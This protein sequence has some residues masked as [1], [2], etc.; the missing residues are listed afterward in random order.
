MRAALKF[1]SSQER[2]DGIYAPVRQV[3]RS[4]GAGATWRINQGTNMGRGA[5][6]RKGATVAR[7]A[8][9]TPILIGRDAVNAF[10]ALI[11]PFSAGDLAQA[12]HV[13]KQTAKCWKN[14]RSIPS[15]DRLMLLGRNLPPV[16]AW[17]QKQM[18]AGGETEFDSPE[19]LDQ[20]ARA[21]VARFDRGGE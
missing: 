9:A 17:V 4:H 11:I 21:L 7:G 18:M 12:A 16:R 5:T 1:V 19:R 15:S 2:T 8:T 10:T 13:S 14:G 6:A 20:I 3:G